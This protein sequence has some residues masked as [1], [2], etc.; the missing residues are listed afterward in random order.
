MKADAEQKSDQVVE[1]AE[2][3]KNQAITEANE[4]TTDAAAKTQE[5]NDSMKKEEAY[6]HVDSTSAERK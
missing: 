6:T 3:I 1:K 5:I 4:L 2:Q